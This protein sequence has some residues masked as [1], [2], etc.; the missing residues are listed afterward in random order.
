MRAGFVHYN[1]ADEVDRLLDRA[2]RAVLTRRRA[3]AGADP[4]RHDEPARQRGGVHRVHRGLL[5]RRG[6]E[7]QIYAREPGAAE[8]RRA[9]RRRG[10]APPLLLYGHVDVV[11]TAGQNWTHPPFEAGSRTATSGAA[12]RST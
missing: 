5:E 1:T 12:A 3:A 10:D 9:P 7:T 8:P 6:L 11:T 2:R 4:V